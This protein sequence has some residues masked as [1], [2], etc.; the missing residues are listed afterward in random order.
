MIL[1]LL[2]LALVWGVAVIFASVRPAVA[3]EESGDSR[4]VAFEKGSR[5]HALHE[6]LEESRHKRLTGVALQAEEKRLGAELSAAVAEEWEVFLASDAT[7]PWPIAMKRALQDKVLARLNV[8]KL[9]KWL[10]R[11]A[12]THGP[13]LAVAYATSETLESACLVLSAMHP[14][15]APLLLPLGM[16]HVGDA[17][18]FGVGLKGPEAA[19]TLRL[20]SRHGGLLQGSQN[21]FR[22]L[23]DQHQAVPLDMDR[24]L[25]VV[26]RPHAASGEL[27]RAAVLSDEA[28][29]ESDAPWARGF[30]EL[31]NP[32]S[33]AQR[34][35]SPHLSLR[36][37]EKIAKQHQIPLK[38]LKPFRSD[39]D[40]YLA[41][42]LNRIDQNP[43]AST[44]LLKLMGQRNDGFGNYWSRVEAPRGVSLNDLLAGKLSAMDLAKAGE[45]PDALARRLLPFV[46][47]QYTELLSEAEAHYNWAPADVR[48]ALKQLRGSLEHDKGLWRMANTSYPAAQE[49]DFENLLQVAHEA[50]LSL[51]SLGGHF[52][53]AHGSDHVH[54]SGHEHNSA[55]SHTVDKATLPWPERCKQIWAQ[56]FRRR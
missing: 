23:V 32:Q 11:V 55:H 22:F 13:A 3:H 29:P 9:G 37:L 15:W 46:R 27:V 47:E 26:E 39:K 8:A 2:R 20:W 43:A 28:W 33:E 44:D 41:L 45:S 48:G 53:H 49:R 38:R 34:R 56:L 42:L 54:G 4:V 50:K 18:V 52:A 1:G 19:R 30:R 21:Y 36:D 6:H 40:V 51:E 25:D 35:T 17:I 31:M 10:L 14:K 12:S 16:S 5:L 7:K 24:V